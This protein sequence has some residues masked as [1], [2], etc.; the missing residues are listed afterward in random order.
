MKR[1]KAKFRRGDWI[2]DADGRLFEYVGRRKHAP[3][4]ILKDLGHTSCV[5]RPWSRPKSE[6]PERILD[7][8]EKVV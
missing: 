1:T 7:T 3:V 8:M 5:N 2:A 4:V 6:W